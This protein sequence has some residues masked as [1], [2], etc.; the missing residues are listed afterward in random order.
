MFPL[1]SGAVSGYSLRGKLYIQQKNI[2]QYH[3]RSEKSKIQGRKFFNLRAD[4]L[5]LIKKVPK[6]E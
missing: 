2:P 6:S 4:G 3:L 1:A 5:I